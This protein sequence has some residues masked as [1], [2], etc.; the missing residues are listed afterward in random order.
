MMIEPEV[1]FHNNATIKVQAQI[2]EGTTL[3]STGLAGPSESCV[4]AAVAGPYDIF[5]KNGATGWELARQLDGEAKIVT[6]SHKNGRYVLT[7]SET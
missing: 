6:L 5:L 1:V 7:G 4:L 2:F 3:I